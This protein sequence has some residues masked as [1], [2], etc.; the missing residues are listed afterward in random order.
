MTG[1]KSNMSR[2]ATR[3]FRK[4]LSLD[5]SDKHEKFIKINQKDFCTFIEFIL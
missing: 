5:F 1:K 2:V 3:F 4:R